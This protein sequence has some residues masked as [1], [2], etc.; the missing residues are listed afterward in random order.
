MTLARTGLGARSTFLPLRASAFTRDRQDGGGG[1]TDD[2]AG[3]DDAADDDGVD[4]DDAGDITD[5][6]DDDDEPLGAAGKKALTEER[7]KVKDL[8]KQN[9]ELRAQLNGKVKPDGKDVETPEDAEA[10]QA[11]DTERARELA[12]PLLVKTEARRLLAEAGLIGKPDG[13]L[14]MLDL[15]A[16]DIDYTDDGDV[17]EIDGLAEQIDTLAEDYPTLFRKKGGGGRIDAADKGGGGGP[18]KKSASEIQ[19]AGLRGGR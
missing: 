4:D 3:A 13:L 2:A 19:A 11:A 14:K 17:D 10:R 9:R 15:K 18:K 6:E 8:K 16:V 12:K 5:D 7:D 1:G